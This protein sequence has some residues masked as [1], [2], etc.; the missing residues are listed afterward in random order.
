MKELKRLALR[1]EMNFA[2]CEASYWIGFCAISGFITV[3]LDHCG[4]KNTEIGLTT[5]IGCAVA[6]IAQLILSNVLDRHPE[7]PIKRLIALLAVIGIVTAALM[8]AFSLPAAMTVIVFATCYASG[9][10]NNGYLNAQLV[11]CN[12]AG[13]PARYG[14]PR[15]VGSFFYAV[16]AYVYGRLVETYSPDILMP[17]FIAGTV[18][19]I[20]FV[21]LMPN[22]NKGKTREELH[23]DRKVTSYR[24]M[25]TKNPM[26]IVLLLC[27]LLNGIGNT[28]GYTF[29]VRV[30]Q[31]VHCNTVEYGISEFI[32]AAAEVPALFASGLLLKYFKPKSLLA[33]S[34]LF[35]GVRLLLLAFA[36]DIGFVYLASAFNMLCVG[37]SAFSSVLLVNS[38]VGDTE[39]VRGQS[40]CVLCGS[41]GSI[42]GSAYAGAMIDHLGLDAMLYTSTFFCLLAFAGMLLFCKPKQK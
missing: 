14:W 35:S 11:Q 8:G 26:L 40:M 34:Y 27:T 5:S 25:I 28:A 24:E 20:G 29:I 22:P 6:I 37:L 32:R 42:I 18:V 3:Y 1:V 9:M 30:V 10:C 12:N 13:I 23:K 2:A 39:K 36:P 4:L 19:C 16:S 21:L 33:V 38:I 41:I 17:A 31:R 15:G 7:L